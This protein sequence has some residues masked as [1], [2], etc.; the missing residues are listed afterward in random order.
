MWWNQ[1][2]KMT[3]FFWSTRNAVS[4]S[5]GNLEKMKSPTHS[6]VGPTRYLF[7]RESESASARAR[8]WGRTRRRARASRTPSALRGARGAGGIRARRD[9]PRVPLGRIGAARPH[10][11]LAQRAPVRRVAQRA[12]QVRQH[13]RG[14][15]EAERRERG[16]PRRERAAQLVRARGQELG[17][18]E[19]HPQVRADREHGDLGVLARVVDHDLRVEVRLEGGEPREQLHGPVAVRRHKLLEDPLRFLGSLDRTRIAG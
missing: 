10:E 15:R 2:R 17:Q 9:G 1:C 5:S 19:D 18:A 8:V 12:Q 7:A 13:A 16:V 11:A 4:R 3:R 6:P 14:A